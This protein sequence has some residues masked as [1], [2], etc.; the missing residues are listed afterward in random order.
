[1]DIP[2]KAKEALI[3]VDYLW[4]SDTHG[5]RIAS[6]LDELRVAVETMCYE[7]LLEPMRTAQGNPS[8]EEFSEWDKQFEG[9]GLFPSLLQ[10][11]SICQQGFFVRYLQGTQLGAE[12]I[13]FLRR[14][15]LTSIEHLRTARN[16]SEHGV[17]VRLTRQEVDPFVRRFLGIGQLGVLRRLSEIGSKLARP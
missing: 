10:Y 14:D 12:E 5:L 13:E 17:D 6:A 11:A 16:P 4:F 15:L 1:M 2:Q 8:L 9:T 3:T 7:F